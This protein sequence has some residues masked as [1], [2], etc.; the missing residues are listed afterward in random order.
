MKTFTSLLLEGKT[1]SIL[2]KKKYPDVIFQLIGPRPPEDG[3]NGFYTLQM[4][5]VPYKLR[6]QGIASKFM[7]DLVTIA[8]KEGNDIMLSPTV[9]YME[10]EM[11]L[12]QLTDWYKK[13]GFRKKKRD[14][15][16]SMNTY[17]LY[18]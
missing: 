2:L 15:F 4:I 8:S 9:E 16:R 10:N 14:D 1:L 13:F 7:K 5:L 17:V 6:Q 12:K 3:E 11:S 18:Q